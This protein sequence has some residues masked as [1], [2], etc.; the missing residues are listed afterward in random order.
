MILS[1]NQPLTFEE[2]KNL[3]KVNDHIK[4]QARVFMLEAVIK[5]KKHNP[6]MGV[7]FLKKCRYYQGVWSLEFDSKP[8]PLKVILCELLKR[9][10]FKNIARNENVYL[11]RLLNVVKMNLEG[12]EFNEA[13]DYFLNCDNEILVNNVRQYETYQIKLKEIDN[14]LNSKSDNEAARNHADVV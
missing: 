2:I 9:G 6:A 7:I 14:I 8:V 13:L 12:P 3:P 11:Y 4:E 1:P 10:D 5:E